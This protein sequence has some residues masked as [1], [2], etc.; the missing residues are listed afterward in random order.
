MFD[1]AELQTSQPFQLT[2]LALRLMAR[3][4]GPLTD[5]TTERPE[6]AQRRSFKARSQES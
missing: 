4:F 6:F 2:P 5:K 1:S 3:V